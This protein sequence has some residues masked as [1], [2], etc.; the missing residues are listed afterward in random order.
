MTFP[1]RSQYRWSRIGFQRAESHIIRDVRV[2]GWGVGAGHPSSCYQGQA[3]PFWLKDI[4][5]V[6][7]SGTGNY[8][9][10]ST[11]KNWIGIRTQPLETHRLSDSLHCELDITV[12]EASGS[13]PGHRCYSLR[14]ILTFFSTNIHEFDEVE[15]YFFR[16]RPDQPWGP[17]SLLYNGYWV[18]VPGAKRPERGV[19]PP[20]ASSAEV[21]ERLELYL[22]SPSGL[23]WSV[24]G[25]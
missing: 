3:S 12:L 5:L 20:F 2:R 9:A 17:S 18:P 7:L 23:S 15:F 6:K 10:A 19:I 25:L 4:E 13:S 22:Y 8:T 11:P 14:F 1:H 21:K 16:N 24:L